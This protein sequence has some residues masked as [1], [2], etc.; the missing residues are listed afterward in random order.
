VKVTLTVTDDDAGVGK[1]EMLFTV[2][3]VAPT[4]TFTASSPVNEG[5]LIA[6][7][8]TN[9]VDPSTVD[10]AAGFQYAFDCGTGTGYSGYSSTSSASC[11]TPDNGPRSV[12]GKIKDKDG[13]ET[14]YTS[15]V[16]V[17]NVP[18]TVTL[19]KPDGTPLS[20]TLIIAGTMDIKV[21][22][23]D[24]GTSDTHKAQVDCGNGSAPFNVNGGAN[25]SSGFQTSCTF[26]SI[27]SKTITVTVT[28]DDGGPG[29]ATHKLTV[30]YNFAGF[31]A[32]VDR[33]N[34][35]NVSKAGQAIP[36]KWRLTDAL[37]HPITN[38]TSVSV[39]TVDLN[40]GL[41]T[42]QDLI[43]EYAAG[44]SG[45]QNLGDGN[46]QFNWK[47]P[48]G[49]AGSCKSIA[50]VFGAGGIGYTENPAA[51]FTFKK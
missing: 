49:Y 41:G 14:E 24:P 30:Q 22:F 21:A 1:D 5:T 4:A 39:Q 10:V 3:N 43:E 45:L 38:L 48:T 33:P 8:L 16:Q 7:S 28:D 12:R 51:Y 15:T 50:L 13:D 6:L 44:A 11:P 25:V 37:G 46:Y 29:V 23:T 47:T 26:P 36:L 17:V 18:P 35:M 9:P 32:P 27:G 19:T 40:C 20:P 34:T 31:F 42:T 2:T